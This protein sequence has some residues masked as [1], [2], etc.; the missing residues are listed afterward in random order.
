MEQGFRVLGIGAINVAFGLVIVLLSA[1]LLAAEERREPNAADEVRTEYR[2]LERLRRGGRYYFGIGGGKSM[3]DPD[4]G[5]TGFRVDDDTGTGIKSMMGYEVTRHV[6]VEV[7]GGSLGASS[8]VNDSQAREKVDYSIYGLNGVFNI[9]GWQ[10]GFSP[11]L[12]LGANKISINSS[13]PH[14]SENDWLFFGGLGLEYESKS[15]VA[16]RVE[17]E[18]FSENTQL[19]SLSLLTYFGGKKAKSYPVPPPEPGAFSEDIS[20]P[21]PVSQENQSTNRVAITPPD[22][23]GDGINDIHD[24]CQ[25]TPVGAKTDGLGC[26]SFEGVVQGVNFEPS[27]ARL[28]PKAKKMLNK[29]AVEL[30]RFPDIK[31]QVEAHTDSQGDPGVNLWLSNSRAQ[32]VIAYLS[33]RGIKSSRLIPI[34]FGE[35]KPIADNATEEGRAKNRRVEFHATKS[36]W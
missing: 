36:R 18:Y 9:E 8:L 21:A 24:A 22:S 14:E 3:L 17:Y 13:L 33:K 7:F 32:S 31:I 1:P 34:G 20:I 35:A 30:K 27:N 19:V 5:A 6:A 10:H 23:D 11:L 12:K 26:A 25:N 16:L 4:P 2:M 29:M 15:R 28:T